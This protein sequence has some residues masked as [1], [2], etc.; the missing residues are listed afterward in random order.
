SDPE[1]IIDAA[2]ASVLI[3]RPNTATMS[4]TVWNALRK[5]PKIVQAV[6][7][8][9]QADGKITREEF[10]AYFELSRLLI[11]AG[12][13]NAAKKGQPTSLQRVWGKGISLTYLDTSIQ[14][15]DMGGITW[16]FSPVFGS[17]VAGTIEDANIGLKGGQVVRVGE[18]ITELVV[19][20][21]A[22]ALIQNAIS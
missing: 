13:V 21:A 4:E 9:T 16:G 14:R 22:G 8:S 19:A 1:A 17:R 3:Y 7:G 10:V 15:A 18:T 12:Y 5:H 11:G 20:K 2:L 6:K